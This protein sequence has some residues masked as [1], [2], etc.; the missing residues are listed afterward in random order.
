MD[1]DIAKVREA[2]DANGYAHLRDIAPPAVVQGLTG[3]IRRDLTSRPDAMQ[4]MLSMKLSVSV[5][6]AYEIYSYRYPPVMGF[7][8]GLTSRMCLVTGKSLLPTYAFFRV[9]QGGD[10]CVVHSDRPSCEHSLS[11][12]L[13]YS[14][15]K[16]WEFS[17]GHNFYEFD[18][19]SKMAIAQDFGEEK[20]STLMLNP[21][22]AILYKGVNHRHGRTKPNPNRWSA[23]LFMHWIDANGPFR[24][25]AFDKQVLPPPGDFPFPSASATSSSATLT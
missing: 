25:W 11:V 20:F 17:I 16:V 4:R 24:D 8:W 2:Y 14:D 7:H 3:I 12:P 1:G 21:G 15:G 6:P 9:Y 19:A 18:V 23:H 13:A 22:D 10:I 5:K